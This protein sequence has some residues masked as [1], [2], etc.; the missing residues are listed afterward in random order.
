M[1]SWGKETKGKRRLI[2]TGKESG[3]EIVSETLIPKTE[4]GNVFE[5]ETVNKGDVINEGSLSPHDIFVT[6]RSN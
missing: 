2:I 3:E 5:G 1:V 6:Q 4:V